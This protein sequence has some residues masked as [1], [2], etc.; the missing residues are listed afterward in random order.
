MSDA[1]NHRERLLRTLRNQPVDRLPDYEFGAWTQTNQRWS[2]EGLDLAACKGLCRTFYYSDRFLGTDDDEYGPTLN[3]KVGMLPTFDEQVL[4]DRG[5]SEIIQDADG[6][7]AEQL[8][9]QFGASIPR[10]IRYA[11][12]NRADW[13]K[14][15]A[16][17]LD[18][19]HPERIPVEIE[20]LARRLRQDD[21]PV[22]VRL[23]SLYGWIRNWVGVENL[24]LMLYDD[25]PLVEEMM[26]HLTQLTL[27]VLEK[28]AGYG[29]VI[30]RCDWWEDMCYNAGPLLSPRLFQELMVP[31]YQRITTFLRR[32]FQTEFN[33]VDCDGNIHALVSRW[34]ES[35]INMMWPLEV[36]A[37]D[38]Y[39]IYNKFG[40]QVKLRGGYDKRAL[41]AGPAAIDAEFERLRPLIEKKALIVHPD[42]LVPPDV[43]F[44]NYLYYRRRKLEMIGKPWREPG[45]RP[46]EGAIQT[47]RLLGPFDNANNQ[48]FH[49]AL[50]PESGHPGPF[51][52]KAE[53]PLTWKPYYGQLASGYVDLKALVSPEPWV[54][55]YAACEIYSPVER[56]SLLEVGSDDGI[57]I[58]INGERICKRDVYR[59]AVPMQDI[60]PVQLKQ[61]WNSVFCKIGQARG[62]WGF[63]FRLTDETGQSWKDIEVKI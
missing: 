43:S 47:W 39:A 14:I 1:L 19:A 5:Q 26:E 40:A 63:H 38:V 44:E 25:R 8:K 56:A 49:T 60:L 51:F 20:T 54:V 29:L 22:I 24:S 13:E 48:G 32:E 11:I 42:H 37:T 36:A 62:E 21:Y 45:I 18:P 55:A 53:Q 7:I 59:L 3:L 2:Q 27:Q 4:E 46:R 35:G 9:A 16:E 17:R 10:Y 6:A 52:G 33:Q 61:G 12:Q 57:Q 34:L 28:V 41:A 50:L 58:W 31:R 23:G 30:D 15:R